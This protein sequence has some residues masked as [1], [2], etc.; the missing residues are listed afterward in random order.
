[1]MAWDGRTLPAIHSEI[2]IIGETGDG[3]Q[4]VADIERLR[5]DLIFLDV[6]MPGL[7][8]IEMLQSLP[9][10]APLPLVIFAI[11]YDEYAMAAFEANAVGYLLKPINRERLDQAV[12]R[13]RKLMLSESLVENE[14]ARI[15]QIIDSATP[16]VSH[17]VGRK[18]DRFVLLRPDQ[19]CL[20]QVENGLVKIK[21]EDE[22]FWIDYQLE[23]LEA[24]LPDPPFFRA[25]RSV[26]VNMGKVKEIAP[27]FKSTYLLIMNDRESSKIQV[28]ERQSK[29]LRRLLRE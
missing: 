10:K 29:K 3:L 20:I 8:G 26:I 27:F 24:R 11:A 14:R 6:Q 16:L 22:A 19:V 15:R 7:T 4:A 25:H 23:D 1:M 18:R 2:E 21:T 17:L 5:P 12:E 28:S 9:K 13:A